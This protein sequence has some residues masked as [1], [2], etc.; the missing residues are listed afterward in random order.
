MQNSLY[1]T[2]QSDGTNEA[3]MQMTDK[4]ASLATD[5]APGQELRQAA[6]NIGDLICGE[7]IAGRL[8]DFSHGD[9]DAFLPTPGAFDRFFEAIAAG[10]RQAYTEYRGSADIRAELAEK[11]AT[12]TGAPISVERGTIITPGTQGALFLAVASLVN[13][14]DKVAIVQPDYFA[15]RKLVQFFGG[16]VLPVTM[17]YMG[18]GSEAGLDL[19]QL[20][21]AFD[22]GA[23]V[24]LFS[25]PNN[26]TG[27]VYSER[28]VVEIAKLVEA[29]G[30]TVI[31]DQLY[32]RLLYEGETYT[33]IRA[34]GVP[35]DRIITIMGPSKTESLSGYR[36]GIAFGSPSIIENMEKLQSIV[37]LRAAGYNQAVLH[38]W[39][40]EPVGW[41]DERIRQH[42]AI[43]DD[44]LSLFREGGI[45]SRTPQAGSYLFPTLPPLA[46]SQHD[47][48]RL[49]RH[50]ANV[51]VTPGNE[52]GPHHDSVRL[53]CSQDQDA[54]IAAA[55]R[56]VTIVHRYLD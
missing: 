49:L 33:H 34:C 3:T 37:S 36:L 22:V 12:F 51:I 44:L 48:V 16:Q 4:F 11:L 1:N 52:F 21:A 24:F 9:I 38:T 28:E 56:I 27:A 25:N 47:F 55:H 43:R 35:E 26:P 40:S 23:K 41:L 10:G 50:Q 53:N 15:N 20:R 17:T 31:A 39:F 19:S 14:N 42:Q 54:A 13:Q 8:V 6:G 2:E 30:V 32:S 18:G 45:A 5:N 46:V 7:S 29:Y